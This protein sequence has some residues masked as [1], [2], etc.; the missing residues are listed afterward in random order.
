MRVIFLGWV[1]HR[2]IKKKAQQYYSLLSRLAGCL[3]RLRRV[4]IA[5]DSNVPVNSFQRL[6]SPNTEPRAADREEKEPEPRS[7]VAD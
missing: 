7:A 1:K 3:W 6:A 4:A 5:A 2:K